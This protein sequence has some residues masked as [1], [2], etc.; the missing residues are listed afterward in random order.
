MMDH[1]AALALLDDHVDGA[2]A[3][4]DEAALGEHLA[5]CPACRAE[6][7]ALRA[8]S[9][10]ARALPEAVE[11]SRDLWPGIAA[12]IEAPVKRP[13]H[14]RPLALAVAAALLVGVTALV[15]RLLAPTAPVPVAEAP[16]A[17][18][19]WEQELTA[20]SMALALA[21]DARRADLTPET[22]AIIDDNLRIIDLA[23]EDCRIALQTDPSNPQL[24][25]SLRAA[26]QRRVR[27]LERA[28]HLPS[29]S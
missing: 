28:R 25:A 27:V 8:L 17:S 21:L 18:I 10:E 2:L 22:A 29:D 6:R 26:W 4:A 13:W 7:D 23:I 12:R 24:E 16:A 1:A 15:T 3:P 5:A 11:P 9:A 14:A 19:P 20:A